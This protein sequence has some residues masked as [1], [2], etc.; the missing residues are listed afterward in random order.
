MR[1]SIGEF[2]ITECKGACCRIGKLPLY[3]Q[4]ETM[5]ISS[6]LKPK[7]LHY[8]HINTNGMQF[9]DLE[10]C[11]CPHLGKKNECKIHNQKRPFMCVEFPVFIKDNMIILASDCKAT[12]NN[13]FVKFLL[14]VKDLGYTII[15]H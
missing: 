4:D 9:F 10:H 7:S 2:C 12:T 8:I 3:S 14:R 11:K 13:Q 1:N 5:I 6:K 15:I